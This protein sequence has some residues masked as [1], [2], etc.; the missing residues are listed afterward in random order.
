M[1][2]N[3][4][5]SNQRGVQKAKLLTCPCLLNPKWWVPGSLRRFPG[6]QIL[7]SL[8]DLDHFKPQKSSPLSSGFQASTSSLIILPE[9]R[10]YG[11]EEEH[12][13]GARKTWV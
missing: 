4:A 11:T 13:F 12:S 5:I 9:V 8:G 1:E 10:V 7:S 3:L 6:S 2:F